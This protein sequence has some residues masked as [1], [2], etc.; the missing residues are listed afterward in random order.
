MNNA[1]PASF[2][3]EYG[4]AAESCVLPAGCSFEEVRRS[5]A[6]CMSDADIGTRIN[7]LLRSPAAQELKNKASAC[8]EAL[9]I[10]DDTTRPTPAAKILPALSGFLELAGVPAAQQTVLFATGSHRAMTDEE[11][12]AK[13]GP[14]MF[15]KL[16]CRCHDWNSRLVRAGRT[17]SGIPVD[18]DPL[19]SAHRC[20]IGIGSVFPHRYCGWSGGGKIVL[21]GVSGPE[22]IAR[23]HWLPAADPSIHLGSKDNLAIRDLRSAAEMAGMSFL[24]QCV[25]DGSGG[26]YDI[27]AGS[28]SAAH[29]AAIEKASSVME[30]RTGAADVVIAQ[31]YPEDIDL[32]Q[33]GKALY[34][35]ENIVAAGGHIIVTAA[36]TEGIG[37]HRR[38]AELIGAE[39]KEILK[40]RNSFNEESLAAAAAYLTFLVRQ[41][42]DIAFVTQSQHA[43]EMAAVTGL[44]F[45]STVQQA[46]SWAMPGSQRLRTA[47]LTEAPLLLPVLQ[48][49]I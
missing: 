45:F 24:F 43:A 18:V 29:A 3:F 33:A 14:E 23:T 10:C 31:A 48:E 15:S 6:S 36:L 41:K 40:Y 25:C 28:V 13:A 44:R 17:Q 7:E 49:G 30:T 5:R 46:L 26:L 37:P 34:S 21:P 12:A 32:W 16:S 19:V 8:R 22:S 11:M 9:I 27:F 42:A 39:E 4:G 38:F 47:A 2:V 1:R 20:I 35:A